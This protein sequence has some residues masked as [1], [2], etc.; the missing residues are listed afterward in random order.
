MDATSVTEGSQAGTGLGA[1]PGSDIE[2]V[3]NSIG[4]GR[5]TVRAGAAV[6]SGRRDV[7]SLWFDPQEGDRLF[8]VGD[9]AA[10]EFVFG[11]RTHVGA[12]NGQGVRH[13]DGAV[14]CGP[15]Q[16]EGKLEPVVPRRGIGQIEGSAPDQLRSFGGSPGK[17]AR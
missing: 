7:V 16:V 6:S 8:Q 2:P 15:Q 10:R 1:F 13:R 11:V 5:R 14:V 12:A 3:G 4:A 17:R 9:P